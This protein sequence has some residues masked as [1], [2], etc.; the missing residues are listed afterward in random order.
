VASIEQGDISDSP[1]VGILTSDMHEDGLPKRQ[2]GCE[3]LGPRAEGLALLRGVDPMQTNCRRAAIV[4]HG[5]RVPIADADHS[6]MELL[7]FDRAD[8]TEG[9]EQDEA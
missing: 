4:E 5:D 7:G 3:L 2:A 8:Q 6:A 1:P 9:N